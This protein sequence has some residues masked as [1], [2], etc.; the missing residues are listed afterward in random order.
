MNNEKGKSKIIVIIIVVVLLLIGI[1]G[2]IWYT[3]NSEKNSLKEYAENSSI[4]KNESYKMDLRIWGELDGKALNYVIMTTNYKNAEKDIRITKGEKE[5]NYI[6]KADKK[7][8]VKDEKLTE[9]QT[10]PYEQTEVFLEGVNKLKDVKFEKNEKDTS[11]RTFKIYS[12]K[13]SSSDMSEIIKAT[14][15]ELKVDKDTEVE[16]HLTEDNKVYRV[17]YRLDKLTIYPSFFGYGTMNPVN[18][19]IYKS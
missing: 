17:Y 12:G 13:I 7:Y 16:V 3:S 10:V 18:L 15:L 8:L 1:I 19:D 6:V 2:A 9:V 4:E 14:E 11:G 5:E